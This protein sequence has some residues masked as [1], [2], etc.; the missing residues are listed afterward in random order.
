MCVCV[1]VCVCVCDSPRPGSAGRQ[2]LSRVVEEGIGALKPT[3]VSFGNDGGTTTLFDSS[4]RLGLLSRAVA[5]LGDTPSNVT[6]SCIISRLG[7]G[8]VQRAIHVTRGLTGLY[9]VGRAAYASL[10]SSAS[11]S[12]PDSLFDNNT[13]GLAGVTVVMLVLAVGLSR[14]HRPSGKR[15]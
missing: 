7:L 12:I 5:E 13:V 4:G 9:L 2:F 15:E 8:F 10:S 14:C 3:F 6:F 11:V 1:C